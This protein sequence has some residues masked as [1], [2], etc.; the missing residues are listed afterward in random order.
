MIRKI[1]IIHFI[2]A[3]RKQ[4]LSET[5]GISFRDNRQ[6]FGMMCP[7]HSLLH[8]HLIEIIL[9]QNREIVTTEIV[10]PKITKRT[11]DKKPVENKSQIFQI[12]PT[13]NHELFVMEEYYF[14]LIVS[15][16]LKKY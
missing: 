6:A 11:R 16:I 13:Y 1:D 12:K 15:V 7:H 10:I 3:I 8:H 4:F 14:I 9:D 5:I 2:N